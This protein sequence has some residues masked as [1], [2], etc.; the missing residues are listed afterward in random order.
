MLYSACLI[1]SDLIC[2]CLIR[3]I[4]RYIKTTP[5]L[6][7][8][9]VF[10]PHIS[11]KS[12]ESLSNDHLQLL[13]GNYYMILY[14][15]LALKKLHPFQ[16]HKHK[17][18]V[19]RRIQKELEILASLKHRHLMSLKAYVH[20]PPDRFNMKFC[21][22]ML[23]NYV[24]CVCWCL[25]HAMVSFKFS[26]MWHGYGD[27]RFLLDQ[28]DFGRTNGTEIMLTNINMPLPDMMTKLLKSERATRSGWCWGGDRWLRSGV[29]VVVLAMSDGS[30]SKQYYIN[31]KEDRT[32]DSI[33]NDTSSNRWIIAST[34]AT[35][36]FQELRSDVP[37]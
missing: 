1:R 35:S 2:A 22:Y 21:L 9:V 7:G 16:V 5:I 27:C 25:V 28:V 17:K 26:P 10:S 4:F 34:Y 24:T 30:G 29:W 6:N 3:C 23:G 18:T 31:S 15:S 19:K 20:Q 32:L 37:K 12:L 8:P 36:L 11:P 33:K 13:G 14:A